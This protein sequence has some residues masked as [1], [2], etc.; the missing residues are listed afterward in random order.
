MNAE[1]N[2]INK[3]DLEIFEDL[4]KKHN[5][6]WQESDNFKEWEV[7]ARN[8]RTMMAMVK[9]LGK[10]GLLILKKHYENRGVQSWK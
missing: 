9:M 8:E 10:D 4:L 2:I 5:W 7:G 3:T 6:N 1:F